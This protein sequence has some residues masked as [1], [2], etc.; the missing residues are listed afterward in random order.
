MNFTELTG[1]RLGLKIEP[2]F[3]HEIY[4]VINVE[5]LLY[6]VERLGQLAGSLGAEGP[7]KSGT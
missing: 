5:H 6:V 7:N 3:K 1:I 2:T 4:E